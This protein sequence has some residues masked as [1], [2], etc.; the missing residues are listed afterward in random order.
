MASMC[1]E[2]FWVLLNSSYWKRH[3]YISDVLLLYLLILHYQSEAMLEQHTN[4]PSGKA[5]VFR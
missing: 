4:S 2:E 1:A 3:R 5:H